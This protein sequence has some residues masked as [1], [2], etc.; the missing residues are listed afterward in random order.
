MLFMFLN[1]K[2]KRIYLDYAA[3]TPLRSSIVALMQ[4][5]FSEVYGNAGAV[6]QEGVKAHRDIEIARGE[7][8]SVL[9]IRPQ[10]IVFTGSGTESNNI[11]IMGV[12]EAKRKEGRAYSDMEVVSTYIEHAS[13]SEVL[14]RLSSLGV[15]VC[16]ADTDEY[17]VIKTESLKMVLTEKTVLVTFAC[18][19]SEIGTIE[20]AG[21]LSRIV[22]AHEKEHGIEIYVHLDAAQAPLWLSCAL[23]S[24]GADIVSF[25]A[26]KCYGPKGIGILAFRHGVSLAPYLYGGEQEGGLRAGTENTALIVGAVA[27]LVIAQKEHVKRSELI[28]K[29]RDGFIAELLEIDGAILNGPTENRVANNVNISIPDIDSE[30]AVITLDEAGIA[31]ATKS[32][33][34]G[35]KGDG[36]GIVMAVTNDKKRATSSIRFSLGEETTQKELSHVAKILKTHVALTR[37]SLQ[38]LTM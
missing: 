38:K 22:K 32:A 24:L 19:N 37:T 15:T 20:P 4:P 21:K 10:G 33:C 1:A 26:G 35:A 27:A 7:L 29:L 34:G 30:F 36:S 9:H 28:E 18:V 31:C 3:A 12:I 6:H 23:D 16:Y 5:Y 2:K 8:A 11:A 13:V 14:K 25:D 17:G